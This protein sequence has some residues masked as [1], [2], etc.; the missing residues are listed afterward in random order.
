MSSTAIPTATPTPTGDPDGPESRPAGARP[1]GRKGELTRRRIVERAAPV[2]NQRGYAGTSLSD[3]VA[4]TGLEK[5]GI[6][7][8]F[9]SK[10]ELA[11][12]AFDHAVELVA[13]R[14]VQAQ[15]GR[16]GLDR[17]VALIESFGS[18][19]DDPVL[20]GG[21]PL[22]NTSIDADDTHPEL[23]ARAKAAMESWHRLVGVI[24]KDAKRRGEV[25][26]DLDPYTLATVVTGGLD[27]SLMLTKVTGDPAHVQ[28]MVAHLVAHVDALR[29]A[30]PATGSGR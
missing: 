3:L 2:F 26:A 8:H 27:G 9:A 7:N 29:L 18:W 12:A 19:V 14:N 17:L 30:P 15:A 11:L 5:G 28:R 10:D 24:L 1:S 25:A 21:C 16:E 4:A 23:A 6:Y 20:P 13:E 22:M